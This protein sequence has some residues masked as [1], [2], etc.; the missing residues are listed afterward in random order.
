MRDEA[1]R[2]VHYLEP[3]LLGSG[4]FS[5]REQAV[6]D[7]INQPD[8]ISQ[9]IDQLMEYLWGVLR[10]LT[11]C[12]RLALAFAMEGGR[13]VVAHWVRAQYEPL[14]LDKGYAADLT[15]SSLETILSTGRP[16][17]IHDLSRYLAEHP[18]SASSKLLVQEGV[19]SSLTCPL[20][21]E[22]RPVGFLFSSSRTPWAVKERHVQFGLAIADRLTPAVERAFRIEQ[23]EAVN[24]DYLEMLGFVSH[25]LKSPI[26]S[27]VTD[28]RVLTEGYLGA[29]EPRQKQKIERMMQKGEYLLDLIRGFLDLARIE[30]GE[31][32][33]R[34]A[35][36]VDLVAA[37]IEPAIEI[38]Q[39][40]LDEKDMRLTRMFPEVKVG[41]E[42]DPHLLKIVMVNYLANAV[43]Y[44]RPS[45]EIRLHVNRILGRLDVAVWNEGQG[46]SD[47]DRSRLFRKF[48]RLPDAEAKPQKGSGLG[49]YNAW[50]IIQL[51]HGKTQAFSEPGQWAE[52]IFSIPQPLPKRA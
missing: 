6:L 33:L 19:R 42:C 1:T 16:R 35:A 7:H 31:L 18:Q 25:E 29:L 8:A 2:V 47:A 51:H 44:G 23:L 12:D 11:P 28:G 34:P 48:S 15:G 17:I 37:V 32:K 40:E 9:S 46:F 13:R 24:R 21:V 10:S 14:L 22:G 4:E 20:V 5:S 52:F 27:L 39:P 50:R 43:K 49:L 30:G 38:V 41:A 3:F 45:G 36:G 26:A